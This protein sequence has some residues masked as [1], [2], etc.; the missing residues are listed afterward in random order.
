MWFVLIG[1]MLLTPVVSVAITAYL[2]FMLHSYWMGNKHITNQSEL[3]RFKH[4]VKIYM[5]VAIFQLGFFSLPVVLYFY[6]ITQE[7]FSLNDSVFVIVPTGLTILFWTNTKKYERRLQ[8]IPLEGR[9]IL[10][11]YV[12]VVDTWRK[13]SLPDW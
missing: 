10:E 7:L 3:E 5:Y 12:Y 11:E 13:R 2:R 9:D 4:I 6:G 1:F 8:T